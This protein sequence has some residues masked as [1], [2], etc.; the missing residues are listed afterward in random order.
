MNPQILGPQG[1]AQEILLPG[2]REQLRT[3]SAHTGGTALSL[4]H[5]QPASQEKLDGLH[6]RLTAEPNLRGNITGTQCPAAEKR[7]NHLNPVGEFEI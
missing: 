2:K 1:N 6:H 7:V 4:G 5:Q 3:F